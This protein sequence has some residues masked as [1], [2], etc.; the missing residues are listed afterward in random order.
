MKK[1]KLRVPNRVILA[2]IRGLGNGETIFIKD[3]T[4]K[5]PRDE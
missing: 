1:L 2:H 5:K 3:Y 4:G